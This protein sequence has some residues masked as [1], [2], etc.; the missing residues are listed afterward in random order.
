MSY[1]EATELYYKLRKA[2]DSSFIDSS[3][4]TNEAII[5]LQKTIN[6][7]KINPEY[8]VAKLKLLTQK[9]GEYKQKLYTLIKS[10]YWL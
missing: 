10:K 9:Q 6:K 1:D 7:D 4:E 3:D 5:L 8:L 2:Y